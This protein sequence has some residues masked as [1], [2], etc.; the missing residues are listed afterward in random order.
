MASW[1]A[2][3]SPS[4]ITRAPR[5]C[6]SKGLPSI[7]RVPLSVTRC[8]APGTSDTAGSAPDCAGDLTLARDEC[9]ESPKGSPDVAAYVTSPAATPAKAIHATRTPAARPRMLASDG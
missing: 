4:L 5:N 1:Q 9:A 6:A 8:S 2:A 3:S 7:A